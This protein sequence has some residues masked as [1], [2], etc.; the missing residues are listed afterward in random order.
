MNIIAVHPAEGADILRLFNIVSY[1]I[2]IAMVTGLA[3]GYRGPRKSYVR[4]MVLW[5][6]AISLGIIISTQGL[7]R[8]GYTV[9]TWL[10]ALSGVVGIEL[11]GEM[12]WRERTRQHAEKED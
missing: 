10:L 9:G 5:A 2:I 4:R 12:M 1:L 6:I 11:F 3:W 7:Y 8:H